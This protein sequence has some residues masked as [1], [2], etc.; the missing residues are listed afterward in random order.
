MILEALDKIAAGKILA[1]AEAER[2]ME[3][4]LAGRASTEQIA[5]LLM[6]LRMRGEALE[7]V[8]GFASRD[9]AARNAD[10][11]SGPSPCGHPAC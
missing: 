4:I 7:E 8:V 10:F 11:S 9:A 6:G 2:V 3:E 5:A 1:R